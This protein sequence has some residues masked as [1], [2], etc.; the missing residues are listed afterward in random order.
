VLVPFSFRQL[1]TEFESHQSGN[2]FD[3]LPEESQSKGENGIVGIKQAEFEPQANVV[4]D[5]MQTV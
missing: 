5:A 2:R 3:Q 1:E 4:Q